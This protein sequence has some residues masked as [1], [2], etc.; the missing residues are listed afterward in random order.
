M[1]NPLQ[2]SGPPQTM[3]SVPP[4]VIDG[5]SGHARIL[6]D[7]VKEQVSDLKADVKVI[8]ESRHSD[9][10]WHIGVIGTATVIILGVVVSVYFR[11]DDKIHDLTISTTKIETKLD[12]LIQRIPPV[13]TPAPKK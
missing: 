8:K 1:A 2:D 7:A 12:D 9:L 13:Q 6:I 4:T 3:A 5:V 10:L 11:I